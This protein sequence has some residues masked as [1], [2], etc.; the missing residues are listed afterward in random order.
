MLNNLDQEKAESIRT[1]LLSSANLRLRK[2]FIGFVNMICRAYHDS[3]DK[4]I[5]LYWKDELIKQ[6]GILRDR[7]PDFCVDRDYRWWL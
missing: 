5:T 6:A 4:K 1:I 2:R 7:L 3:W